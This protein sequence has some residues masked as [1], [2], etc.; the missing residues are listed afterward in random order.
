MAL[1]ARYWERREFLSFSLSLYLLRLHPRFNFFTNSKSYLWCRSGRSIT[2]LACSFLLSRLTILQSSASRYTSP[3]SSICPAGEGYSPRSLLL[4]APDS[5]SIVPLLL[6]RRKVRRY[7]DSAG[8]LVAL[9]AGIGTKAWPLLSTGINEPYNGA[10]FLRGY[11]TNGR[12][13]AAKG[14]PILRELAPVR[15]PVDAG[16]RR[17][18]FSEGLTGRL[19]C[20]RLANRPRRVSPFVLFS[21]LERSRG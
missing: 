10:R 11:P 7:A 20:S 12:A 16:K 2:P 9:I 5:V 19:T 15:F 17:F 21:L 1:N 18:S 4:A 8:V 14:A 6:V 3:S 13:E